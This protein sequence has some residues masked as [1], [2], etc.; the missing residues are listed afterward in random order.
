MCIRDSFTSV[1]DLD[2]TPGAEIPINIGGALK[3][4]N[5]NSRSSYNYQISTGSWAASPGGITDLNGTAGNEILIVASD[6][7]KVVDHR[8]RSVSSQPMSGTC[9]LYTSR[10]V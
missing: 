6:S 1:Q 8:A 5:H 9:L 7:L 10:C 4:I 2:G 3:V